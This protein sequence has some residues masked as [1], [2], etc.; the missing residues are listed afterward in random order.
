MAAEGEAPVAGRKPFSWARARPSA[1]SAARSSARFCGSA[2]R[3]IVSESFSPRIHGDERHAVGLADRVD[4][5]DVRVLER[6]GRPCFLQQ[7]FPSTGVVD[8]VLGKDLER[9]LPSQV[10]VPG[11]VDDA[12]AAP[13]DFVEDFVVA[14]RPANHGVGE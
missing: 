10:Q 13:A 7:P 11:A 2:P 5:G 1:T 3:A 12:H 8:Q 9:H 14:E 4:D 6:R